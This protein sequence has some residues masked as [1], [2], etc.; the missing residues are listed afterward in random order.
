MHSSLSRHAA[1]ILLSASAG[2]LLLGPGVAN[3]VTEFSTGGAE[4][5]AFLARASNNVYAAAYGG[6]LYRSTD[7]NPNSGTNWSRVTLPSG[8]HYLTSI[9]GNTSTTMVVGA[10]EGLFTSTDGV[11]FTKRLFEP[12]SAVAMGTGA[13]TTVLA[14]V[15]GL[16]ILRSTNSGVN[17]SASDNTDFAGTDITAMCEDPTNANVF[18]VAAKPDGGG[19]RGGIY[20][21]TDGGQNWALATAI[22]TPAEK[23]QVFG[24]AV[25]SSGSLYAAV[26]RLSD[27]GGGVYKLTGFPGSWAL[28]VNTYGNVSVHRDANT[29]A[30]IWSGMLRLGI[31]RQVGGAGNFDYQHADGGLPTF[32]Y[33]AVNAI[34]TVPGTTITLQALKGAGV[35][36]ATS[37][38]GPATT[39]TRVIFP[40]AER[41]LSAAGV[42]GNANSLMLGLHAGGVWRSNTAGNA[43]ST[44]FP[45]T[46]TNAQ[47]DFSFGAGPTAVNAFVSIWDIAA[48][49]LDPNWIYVAAGNT[50]MHYLNDAGSIFRWNGSVWQG[51]STTTSAP[52]PYNIVQEA[53]SPIVTAGFNPVYGVTQLKGNDNVTFS[54][55]LTGS[56]ALIIRNAGTWTTVAT[57]GITPQ[58][59]SIVNA[60]VPNNT[61]LIALPFD[62]KPIYSTNTGSNWTQSSVGQTGFERLRFFATAENPTNANNWVA[63]SNKG[64][65]MS[66]DAGVSWARVASGVF[67]QYAFTAVGFKS[68]GRAFAADFGGNRYC[69]NNGG[70]TWT[71][72]A[73]GALRAGVNSIRVVNGALYYLTDGA[74]AQ[75]EDLSC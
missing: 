47:A 15:K 69:S 36:R 26:F 29:P 16:G 30:N 54:G 18:Y 28:Q 49:P 12:V 73:G 13:S 25:D 41:V 31:T 58:I 14:A 51:I 20:R 38:G 50:G 35:W 59:R 34:A 6:G 46:V 68:D 66:S 1:R 61:R 37:I 11:N 39:W 75:R 9:A 3:A 42:A 44:F 45:P 57:P 74:G 4:V 71:L 60:N 63:A 56:G 40:G 27:G 62:D 33:T 8:E 65:F 48:S 64:I 10:E 53:G 19:N 5:R 17:F 72:L 52:A 24:L 67:L 21:T 2:L 70:S 32:F 55:W 23:G 7:A 22:T 43:S